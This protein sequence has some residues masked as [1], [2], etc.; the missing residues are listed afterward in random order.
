MMGKFQRM[1]FGRYM[2][3]VVDG[4]AGGGAPAPAAG[5]TGSAAPA[6]SGPTGATGVSNL[7]ADGPTGATGATGPAG[8]TGATSAAPEPVKPDDA[9]ALLLQKG[10]KQEDIDKLTPEDL[11]KKHGEMKDQPD[12]ITLKLPD[13][14]TMAEADQKAFTDAVLDAKLTPTEKAQKLF[15]MHVAAITKH[16]TDSYEA[17]TKLQTDW[18]ATVKA[19]KELGGANF[20][21]M[22]STIAKAIDAIGGAEAAKI[23]EGFVVT[24]AGN[25]PEVVRMFYRM[26]KA[27]TEGGHV[28]GGALASGTKDFATRVQSM[29]PS[30]ADGAA[31]T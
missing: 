12:P 23:R 21:A 19:D 17:F 20:D 15:D 29:Y 30:A 22:Q 5:A 14:I 18:Q 9:K 2:Q 31:K 25:Q 27:L 8:P 26:A 16:A 10:M 1:L 4:S 6:A 28:A 24:G 11:L 7:I 3:A 13:G